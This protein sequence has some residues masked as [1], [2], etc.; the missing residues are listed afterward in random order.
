VLAAA[1][2]RGPLAGG[3]A[4]AWAGLLLDM[5]PP[6]AGPLGGWLLV[7]VAV[8]A[9]MG[10]AVATGRPGPFGAMLLMAAGAAAAVLARTA[11]LWFAGVPVAPSAGLAALA[12]GGYGL[13]LAP[14]ALLVAARSRPDLSASR[15][16]DQPLTPVRAQ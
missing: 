12:S 5:L 4:G 13:L 8:G 2:A 16:G 11:V 3:L 1:Y 14:A 9:G 6:A 7:L 15:G 10:Q